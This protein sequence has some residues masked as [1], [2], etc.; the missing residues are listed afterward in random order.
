MQKP[1]CSIIR[2][3]NTKFAA[4]RASPSLGLAPEDGN[5]GSEFYFFNST[6]VSGTACPNLSLLLPPKRWVWLFLG[7]IWLFPCDQNWLSAS[8]GNCLLWC[9]PQRGQSWKLHSQRLW[10]TAM[11][12][13]Q[14]HAPAPSTCRVPSVSPWMSWSTAG[15]HL[16]VLAHGPMS[17]IHPGE[18][19]G[20]AAP[21][22]CF[23]GDEP[24]ALV[25]T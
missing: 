3:T 23:A 2:H 7:R 1:S 17:S 12:D 20:A 25:T 15:K 5:G 6:S 19:M 22:R 13:C 10:W 11:P 16:T 8:Q 24:G 4:A 9:T 18:E 21:S 14:P